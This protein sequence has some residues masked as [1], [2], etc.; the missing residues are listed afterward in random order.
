VRP[1]FDRPDIVVPVQWYRASPS[2]E[3]MPYVNAF[4][5]RISLVEDFVPHVGINYEFNPNSV[6]NFGGWKGI[7][8]CG[9]PDAWRYGVSWLNPPPPCNCAREAVV[10]V[11]EVP[12]GLVDGTNR[13]FT[14]SQVPMSVASCLLQ[15]DGVTLTQGVDYSLSGQTIFLNVLQTPQTGDNLLAYYWVQ[16]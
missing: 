10:P 16:T 3:F 12:A 6:G 13:T 8:P 15:L 5:N 7:A 4:A 14:L 2:A 9:G 11:Q 1:Y